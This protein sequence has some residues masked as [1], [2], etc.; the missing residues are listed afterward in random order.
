MNSWI[1]VYV[2]S[3]FSIHQTKARIFK[4]KCSTMWCLSKTFVLI[5]SKI[6]FPS[7]IIDFLRK[8]FFKMLVKHI[9]I[10]WHFWQ[11][12]VYSFLFCL[13]ASHEYPFPRACKCATS[14]LCEVPL[15]LT[16]NTFLFG[17]GVIIFW[18][19]YNILKMAYSKL[20]SGIL[21]PNGSLS[22]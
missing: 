19:S 8:P 16:T 2:I 9:G 20:F 18:K 3:W 14:V 4:I 1:A 11:L 6:V 13:T 17:I 22:I 10:F 21:H 7:R 5:K 12:F 15:Y